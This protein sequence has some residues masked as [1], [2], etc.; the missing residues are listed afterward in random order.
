MNFGDQLSAPRRH[1]PADVAEFVAFPIVAQAFEFTPMPALPLQP[2]FELDL[3]AANQVDAHF[4]RFFDIGIDAHVLGK[5]R[6]RPS[7]GQAHRTL[8]A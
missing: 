6:S 2:F 7:L 3:T 5:R 1:A 8:V 4:L